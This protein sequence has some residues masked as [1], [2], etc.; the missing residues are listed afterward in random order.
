MT[1][2]DF[3]AKFSGISGM[4]AQ[5]LAAQKL[6][7]ALAEAHSRIFGS[8]LTARK[9]AAALA[10]ADSRNFGSQLQHGCSVVKIH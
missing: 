2:F 1:H 9:L 4:P 10:E 6:A 5:K 3:S 8:Q 7:A